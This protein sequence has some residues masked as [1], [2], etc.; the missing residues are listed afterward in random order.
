[1]RSARHAVPAALL[2]L[3]FTAPRGVIALDVDVVGVPGRS[4]P[5]A[6]RSRRRGGRDHVRDSA[7]VTTT[8]LRMAQV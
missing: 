6:Q 5:A 2:G 1:M 7:T 3:T 8:T 4:T